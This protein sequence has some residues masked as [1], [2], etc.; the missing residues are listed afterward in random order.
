M[1]KWHTAHPQA[2]FIARLLEPHRLRA[3]GKGSEL[4]ALHKS[5]ASP[6]C[7]APTTATHSRPAAR[8][9]D[10]LQSK[11]TKKAVIRV[12]C[13]EWRLSAL[14]SRCRASE[15]REDAP[16]A[17]GKKVRS[18]DLHPP[19]MLQDARTVGKRKLHCGVTRSSEIL[20]RA[21]CAT[22]HFCSCYRDDAAPQRDAR[23]DGIGLRD[24]TRS[25]V[26]VS[27]RVGRGAKIHI[28]I[29]CLL[30]ASVAT[31]TTLSQVTAS[32]G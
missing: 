14:S 23:G 10:G 6:P 3:N 27:V 22:I 9:R 29:S 4:N 19:K 1:R 5:R 28:S 17:N 30:T 18:T 16:A 2:A 12:V 31:L 21:G 15:T 26:S 11:R 7:L 32:R 13:S 24:L 8:N 25:C 20:L